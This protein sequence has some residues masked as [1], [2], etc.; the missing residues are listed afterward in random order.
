ME[1]LRS[2]KERVWVYVYWV[3]VI[4]L[5]LLGQNGDL[6]LELDSE[7]QLH[8]ELLARNLDDHSIHIFI[9]YYVEDI[10]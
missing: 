9:N 3:T 2:M 6:Y 4:C 1:I 8:L 5:K 7:E 10:L